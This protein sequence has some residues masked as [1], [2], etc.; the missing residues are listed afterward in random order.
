MT[1]SDR[2]RLDVERQPAALGVRE[3]VARYGQMASSYDWWAGLFESK[4]QDRALELASVQDE[5]RVLE[6]ALGTGITFERLVKAN[7]R[8]LTIGV[9]ATPEML[10][11]SRSRVGG[12]RGTL[13]RADCRN[14]PFEAATFDVLFSAYLLDLLDVEDMK[15]TVTEFHSVLKPG[16]RLALV[17][18]TFGGLLERPWRWIYGLRPGLLGGCRAIS[19]L[20]LVEAEGFTQP[21]REVVSQWGFAS[22]IVTAVA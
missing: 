3:A 11:R 21:R 8:G 10:A 9:D 14:L 5:T 19:S 18:M 2:E 20:S 17:S 6:V 7:P 1:A 4:A 13:L 22:E 15:T 12:S 16:G